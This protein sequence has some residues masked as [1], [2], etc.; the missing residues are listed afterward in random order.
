MEAAYPQNATIPKLFE[1]LT[2]RGVTF[3]NR[4]F[5]VG[6]IHATGFTDKL[7]VSYYYYSP[8]CANIVQTMDMPQTG[9]LSILV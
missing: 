2:L 4:I 1:P 3:K 6:T 7:N 8:R 9:I 5:V